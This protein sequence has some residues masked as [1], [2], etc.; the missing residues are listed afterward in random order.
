MSF[1][2]VNLNV[3]DEERLS[4]YSSKASLTVDK[5]GGEFVAKGPVT[6]LHESNEYEKVVVIQ[7]PDSDVANNWY[8]SA[9][10]QE[11]IPL[12]NQA[13]ESVFQLV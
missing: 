1:V 3:L 10:Y 5:F 6:F 8:N 4:K 7:F 13:M 11:L 12:R 2:I 9:E